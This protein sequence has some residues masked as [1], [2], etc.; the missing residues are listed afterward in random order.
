[1][2]HLLEGKNKC[3]EKIESLIDKDLND[4]ILKSI[5]GAYFTSLSK[6]KLTNN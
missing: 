2:K 4:R 6:I 1:M 3:L 5:F